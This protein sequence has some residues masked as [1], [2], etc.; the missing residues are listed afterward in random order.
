MPK[1]NLK[2]V[3]L[4]VGLGIAGSIMELKEAIGKG[5]K[6]SVQNGY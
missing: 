2:Y 5:L 6:K 3:A 1:Q 4:T